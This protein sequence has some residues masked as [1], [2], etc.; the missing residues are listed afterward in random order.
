ME[1]SISIS[2]YS[3]RKIPLIYVL[4]LKMFIETC[5]TNTKT[6]LKVCFNCFN[7]VFFVLGICYIC[8]NIKKTQ[9]TITSRMA[10]ESRRDL[11]YETPSWK[12]CCS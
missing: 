8:E 4:M 6:S 3:R 1:E 5:Y 7:V 11:S 9:T 12:R 10:V 2:V